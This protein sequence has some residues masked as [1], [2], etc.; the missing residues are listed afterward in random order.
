MNEQTKVPLCS[1][2]L[3]PLWGRCPASPLS[4]KLS[5]KTR[6]GAER[7]R[8]FNNWTIEGPLELN[9]ALAT[10]LIS[11]HGL[12]WSRKT[13]FNCWWLPHPQKSK[14][15]TAFRSYLFRPKYCFIN[16]SPCFKA[17][18]LP[19]MAW[20]LSHKD[21]HKTVQPWIR[22]HRHLNY[23]DLKPVKEVLWCTKKA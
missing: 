16:Q 22:P 11:L 3:C 9:G 7:E 13:I 18:N 12:L 8:E 10:A 15:S 5:S 20:K 14:R 21:P 4:K 19:S 23:S 2:G 17:L 1:A 6:Q